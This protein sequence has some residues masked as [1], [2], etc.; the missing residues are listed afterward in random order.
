MNHKEKIFQKAKRTFDKEVDLVKILKRI[1]DIEKLKLILFDE[2]QLT[3]FN[4]LTKPTIYASEIDTLGDLE[5][6]ASPSA[7][8]SLLINRKS[9]KHNIVKSYQE[10]KN[11]ACKNS[12]DERLIHFLDLK[13][14]HL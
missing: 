2:N 5:G 7:R 14:N 10:V 8:M 3:M 9:K 11:K 4:F 13:T 1:H 12:V 6:N